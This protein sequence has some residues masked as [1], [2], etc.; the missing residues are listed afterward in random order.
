MQRR[1]Q[2]SGSNCWRRNTCEPPAAAAGR[3]PHLGSTMPADGSRV[4]C[5]T[6]PSTTASLS[7]PRGKRLPYVA[8]LLATG[9]LIGGMSLHR[10]E[11]AAQRVD[12]LMRYRPDHWAGPVN[13]EC[14]LLLL[15]HAFDTLGLNRVQLGSNRPARRAGRPPSRSLEARPSARARCGRT[16]SPVVWR[17][18][19]H[20]GVRD[21]R[22]RLAAG[23]SRNPALR[24]RRP[25]RRKNEEF[26]RGGRRGR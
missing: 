13:P 5:S 16:R 9:E 15:A 3:R 4:G 14:K 21:H 12:R 24:P 23:E 6:S 19:E 22:T 25:S 2:W 18:R 26:H 7:A 10:T 8:R 11:R 20:G 1:A 17:I